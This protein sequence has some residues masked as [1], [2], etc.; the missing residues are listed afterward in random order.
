MQRP[1]IQSLLPTDEPF[2]CP[3]G[4]GGLP[5]T[6]GEAPLSASESVPKPSAATV[7][8]DFFFLLENS[9]GNGWLMERVWRGCEGR[10]EGW[11]SSSEELDS[12]RMFCRSSKLPQL[13]TLPRLPHGS[14]SDTL[15]LLL[16]RPMMG[17]A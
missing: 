2:R 13:P 12:A 17:S 3:R 16:Y 15:E 4:G 1:V 8:A 14:R 10:F 6:I 5:P 7:G 9:E 11:R